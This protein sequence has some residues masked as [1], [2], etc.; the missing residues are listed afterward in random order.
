MRTTPP[1]LILVV[2]LLAVCGGCVRQYLVATQNLERAADGEVS[3][4]RIAL[5]AH[6]PGEQ[7]Y[8]YLR[9]TQ[10]T[11]LGPG[12]IE[13]TTR[14]RVPVRRSTRIAGLV[15]LGAGSVLLG[16]GIWALVPPSQ[17]S[18]PNCG[19]FGVLIG[20]PLV[21]TSVALLIPGAALTL[22]HDAEEIPPGKPGMF[23]I[24][25]LQPPGKP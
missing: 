15:L 6:A 18:C 9:Y 20:L 5:Q 23:F 3:P 25:P 11:V 22:L 10:L 1:L 2:L 8:P 13:G 7:R 4:K 21:V 16:T 24:P 12:N 19:A 14:V 17:E